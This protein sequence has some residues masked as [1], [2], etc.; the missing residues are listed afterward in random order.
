MHFFK[1]VVFVFFI[2]IPRSGNA[3]TYGSSTFSFLR[4]LCA[5]FHSGCSHFL[6][7]PAAHRRSRFSTSSSAWISCG[8]FDVC[9]SDRY[10]VTSHLMVVFH[11][12]DDQQ[13][14][15]SFHIPVGHLHVCFGKMSI[16]VFCPFFIGSFFYIELYKLFKYFGY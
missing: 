9:H 13:C 6:V 8:L 14:S 10:E 7:P 2:K 11:F 16:Q 3:G 4:S 12:F 1:L 5:L 15:V